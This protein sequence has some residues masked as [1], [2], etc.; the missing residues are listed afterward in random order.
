MN[1]LLFGIVLVALL[2][3]HDFIITGIKAICHAM[4]RAYFDYKDHSVW[5][6]L[7]LIII[8]SILISLY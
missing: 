1:L 7:V 5:F 4:S 2:L 8:L 6:R 3:V